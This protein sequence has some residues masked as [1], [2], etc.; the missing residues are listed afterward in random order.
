MSHNKDLLPQLSEKLELILDYFYKYREIVYDVQGVRDHG[1]DLVLKYEKDDES[2]KIGFQVKSF[3]DINEDNWQ[4]K[5]KAQMY[6]AET[7][8]GHS[9]DDFYVLFCTDIQ[10]HRDKLR[11]ATAD[12]TANNKFVSHPISPPKIL[13]FLK[14][15]EAEIGAYIKRRLSEHDYVFTEAAD[16]L[17]GYSRT[18]G[19]MVID[20]LVDMLFEGAQLIAEDICESPLAAFVLDKYP[21]ESDTPFEESVMRIADGRFFYQETYTGQ[22]KLHDGA[23]EAIAAVAY[24]ARVRYGYSKDDL[25]SYLFHTLMADQ[26]DEATADKYGEPSRQSMKECLPFRLVTLNVGNQ[27]DIGRLTEWMPSSAMAEMLSRGEIHP[28]V[29][30][31]LPPASATPS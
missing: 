4:T 19:A 30:P 29:T 1:V 24:D 14:L 25:K 12:L 22:L 20:G 16:S 13:H 5:L 28:L 6:E 8:H 3:N 10:Q 2:R 9:M 23:A 17:G 7:Y 31:C 21:N 26:I 27:H 15:S 11:N 18:E